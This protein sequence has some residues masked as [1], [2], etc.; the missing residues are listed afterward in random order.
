MPG[1]RYAALLRRLRRRTFLSRE[2]VIRRVRT[3][4]VKSEGLERCPTL[5]TANSLSSVDPQIQQLNLNWNWLSDLDRARAVSNIK[6]AS[7]LSNYSLAHKLPVSE[8]TLRRLLIAL[9]APTKDLALARE[10]KISMNEL[11]RRAKAARARRS[12][13]QLQSQAE[14]GADLIC[15][16]LRS[17][18]MNGPNCEVILN[19]VR[20]ELRDQQ[21]NGV[22]PTRPTPSNLSID[23]IIERSKPPAITDDIHITAWYA[24]WL[25]RW[26]F[27]IFPDYNIQSEAL[28]VALRR[29]EGRW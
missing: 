11:V 24:G 6:N 3:I 17:I 1:T 27:F 15:N 23:Q 2:Y 12:Q 21:H 8:P 9:E 7:D 26:A 16:W 22:L 4:L 20:R 18:D 13:Q 5:M 29:V 19:E 10:G 25:F 14:K 28:D